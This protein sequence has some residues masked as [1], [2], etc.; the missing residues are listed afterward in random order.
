MRVALLAHNHHPIA[1][2]FSGGL[3]AHTA[4]VADELVRRGHHVTLFAKAGSRTRARLHPVVSRGFVAGAAFDGYGIDRSNDIADR[5]MTRAAAA[6]HTGAYDVILNNSLNPVPYLAYAD[7]P[8]VTIL[9]TPATLDRINAVIDDPSWQPGDQHAFAAV[10]GVT[11][12]DWQQRLL[13]VTVACVPNGIDLAHWAPRRDSTAR[14]RLAVWAARITPEKG[15][16]VAIAA[17]RAAGFELEFCGPVASREHFRRDIEPLLGDDVR[18]VGHL[19]H[20]ALPR[21][22][23]RGAV[24]VSSP[25]W[26]EP[27]GLS[28]VEAMASGTPAAA[29]PR[30]AAAEVVSRDGGVLA[31]DRSIAALAEA[32][33]AASRL[34]RVQVRRSVGRFDKMT[35]VDTYER[36]LGDAVRSGVRDERVGLNVA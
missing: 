8:M 29:L 28:L 1:E 19:D 26:D 7:R 9:H 4:V 16:P 13:G 34:D 11:T 31:R 32:I 24:F 30:G 5:G 21:F 20:Q 33:V 17:A 14:G 12:A 10:S 23:Q 3:E 2:P 36:L 15:L 27:F 22:L 35:M 18:Y 25:Q 6:I